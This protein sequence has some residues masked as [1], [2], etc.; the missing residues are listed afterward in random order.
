MTGQKTFI[1]W[2]RFRTKSDCQAIFVALQSCFTAG[3]DCLV[4]G[5]QESGKDGWTLRRT[6]NFA[7]EYIGAI[8]YGGDSQRG[9]ARVDINGSG[10]KWLIPE[11]A[12][13][14]ID[15]LHEPEIKRLDIALDTFDGSVSK[16]IAF[17][18]HASG[19]FDRGGR[20]PGKEIYDKYESG[21]TFYVGSR[22]SSRYIRIYCKGAELLKNCKAADLAFIRSNPDIEICWDGVHKS[23]IDKYVRLEVEFK[24]KDGFI[25]PWTALT[26]RDSFFAGVGPYLASM[27]DASPVRIQGMPSALTAQLSM[28]AS[29]EHARI[30][31]GKVI[32]TRLMQLGDTLENRLK[33]FDELVSDEPSPRLVALGILSIPE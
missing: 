33:I 23:T 19:G 32:K 10:S 9:W 16:E 22:S 25:V 6:L 13:N 11:K 17:S 20:R 8:D 3:I 21:F 18:Q 31:Y 15:V 24:P 5:P 7:D 27:V 30:G 12:A 4:L 28:Y 26:Q 2:F 29:M 1:D 14:L